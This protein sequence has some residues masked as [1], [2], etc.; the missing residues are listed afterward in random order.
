MG[1][2]NPSRGR[3]RQAGGRRTTGFGPCRETDP[4]VTLGCATQRSCPCAILALARAKLW[5]G[6][7]LCRDIQG[8]IQHT[9]ARRSKGSDR[10]KAPRFAY[11]SRPGGRPAGRVEVEGE[12]DQRKY[13]PLGIRGSKPG[14]P[15]S[16]AERKRRDKGTFRVRAQF[17]RA[18]AKAIVDTLAVQAQSEATGT[19]SV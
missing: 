17:R 1:R 14:E 18:K 2:S 13:L 11:R 10:V 6:S 9:A 4:R 5:F 12:G 19:S 3:V 8:F 7:P 15:P 16:N